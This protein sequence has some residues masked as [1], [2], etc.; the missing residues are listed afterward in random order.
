M[1][2][3]D[4]I[5]TNDAGQVLH[6]K[7]VS[8][9][10]SVSLSTDDFEQVVGTENSR[11][12]SLTSD[13]RIAATPE[14]SRFLLIGAI[15]QAGHTL[16][17]SFRCV[18]TVNSIPY[19]VGRAQ[20][21]SSARTM[22]PDSIVLE[23]VDD[24]A[25]FWQI[26]ALN[27]LRVLNIGEFEVTEE[28]ILQS[29]EESWDTG[30]PVI[31]AP[32]IY[33][34]PTG[35]YRR[36]PIIEVPRAAFH[37]RD[38][39]PSVYYPAIFEAIE[40]LTGYKFESNFFALPIFQDHIYMYRISD[41]DLKDSVPPECYFEAE[42]AP[43]SYANESVI[44]W[45]DQ[46][47]ACG[48]DFAEWD[49]AIY[50]ALEDHTF[51]LQIWIEA[52][53][54]LLVSMEKENP[55][56]PGVWLPVFAWN[57]V[58]NDRV[59]GAGTFSVLEGERLR[60]RIFTLDDGDPETPTWFDANLTA[61]YVR[62][63]IDKTGTGLLGRTLYIQSFLHDKPV[64]DFMRGV[65]H[66]FCLA[67]LVDPLTKRVFV[68]PRFDYYIEGVKHTGF[69]G[70]MR[71]QLAGDMSSVTTIR[72]DYFGRYLEL[73]F[74]Q[75]GG[76]RFELRDDGDGMPV[77]GVRY[78]M[79]D[80]AQAVAKRNVNPFWQVLTQFRGSGFDVV[81]YYLPAFMED[82]W[83]PGQPLPQGD[84]QAGQLLPPDYETKGNPTCALLQRGNAYIEYDD[85]DEET[86][87]VGYLLPWP[88]QYIENALPN[89]YP[90]EK[91]YCA[92]YCESN[93]MLT[94]QASEILPGLASMFYLTFLA[95]TQC[96]E[97]I[98]TGAKIRAPFVASLPFRG[99]FI[100]PQPHNTA[101]WLLLQID[102]FNP[103]TSAITRMVLL[104]KKQPTLA[105]LFNLRHWRFDYFD[106]AEEICDEAA[107]DETEHPETSRDVVSIQNRAGWVL[108]LR[109]PFVGS[110]AGEPARLRSELEAVL[111]YSETPY[112]SVTVSCV[113]VA[114][115]ERWTVEVQG[116]SA[117]LLYLRLNLGD[118][119]RSER[120]T[121][122]KTC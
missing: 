74:I 72:E 18:V 61:G 23:L 40:R 25:E 4:V 99:E 109:Y 58:V 90:L 35:T 120:L 53:N 51:N 5:L 17:Q 19:F 45:T 10:T 6:V 41:A 112:T 52:T 84:W 39:R 66:Q 50:E 97:E 76:V 85:G 60:F 86:D 54:M 27:S 77:E 114:M 16:C 46:V 24:P 95:T 64:R 22:T 42:A 108:P 115:V 2:R 44:A 43:N 62:G 7:S 113:F 65:S 121:F 59:E 79:P 1:N 102:G 28:T 71:K 33:G 20:V 89:G 15:T 92:S 3:I 91:P 106:L 56:N 73:C 69:Y 63:D 88:C 49:G 47:F 37:I 34:Q 36:D 103:V 117:N 98:R 8:L 32:A 96:P 118:G 107:T 26:C 48:D 68:E 12:P 119:A 38:F 93:A 31:F 14:N 81:T 30:W 55:D 67:W 116:T 83:Q 110:L 100:V 21:K 122:V 75:E 9:T 87:S 105:E 80:G 82:D 111:M 101:E 78:L 70:Q 29:W 13:I 57:Q 11:Y 94:G 104:K